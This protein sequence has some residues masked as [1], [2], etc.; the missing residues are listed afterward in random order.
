M[1]TNTLFR[2]AVVAIASNTVAAA[3]AAA[4]TTKTQTGGG[5][6]GGADQ[7]DV[8]ND[9]ISH[10][11]GWTWAAVLSAFIVYEVVLHLMR[12]VRTVACLNN[13]KQRYFAVPNAT[14]GKFKRYLLDAPLFRTRH[15]R[16]FR[17]SAALNIGTLPSRLQMG[18]LV[19]YF[20]TNVAFCVIS[21]DWSA[22]LAEVAPELRNRTGVLAVMNM[23]PLFLL[24]GRNNPFIAL[25]GISFD[26]FNLIHRWIGRI[27]VF[28]A[29]THTAAYLATKI[30][31]V[32]WAGFAE[33]L[34]K[35]DFILSGFVGACAF[36]FLLLHSPSAIRHAFYETFLHAH[37]LV[38]ATAVGAVWIH[39][40]ELP[41]LRILYGVVTIWVFER[42]LR[43]FRIIL[44]NIGSGGTKADIEALP[45]DA[46]RVTI[47]MARPWKFRPGQHVYIY[48]P[49]IG[50]WTNHPFSLAWSEEEEDLSS[51][52]SEKRLSIPMSTQDV[53]AMR[54]TTMS[55]IVRRRT[56]FTDRL[57]RR[58]AASATGRITTTAVVEGPY[59]GE[60]LS[61]YGTVM[62][63]AA[64]IGIAHQVPHVR[65][66]VG[67]FANGTT[68]TRRL[69]LVWIIQSPEHLEW[70]RPWMT[71]ILAMPRRRE[72]LKILLFVT[73]PRSTKEIQSP[74]ASVQMFPGK[75][76]VEALVEQ[77]R[78]E[79]VGAAVVSCCGTGSLADE[80]R[81]A[82]RTR[83][84]TWN[85]DFRE[86]S[87]SW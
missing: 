59:G 12:Y 52:S 21:I 61:S 64:G 6:T 79:S 87:F 22:P 80:L 10:W 33:T 84:E 35:S 78:V 14:Y 19:A 69:T 73:R 74:S 1:S 76:N 39:L 60:S 45:G 82:V 25:C 36:T 46:V 66:I 72:V 44:R 47:R 5:T 81:R 71:T 15:H 83:E 55:L 23:L 7:A 75:P 11:L 3:A 62:L 24:A 49:S 58:A 18:Y 56:G 20:G 50:L 41:Q 37:I 86:E 38:A 42:S 68:A 65:S 63:W 85:V 53:L 67:A 13:E 43:L 2:W 77:E 31:Q 51:A 54:K 9:H 30:P 17:F 26:T 48:M 27:V 28:E 29:I 32:G 16:E 57:Y 70:I 8:E 34:Q 40:K 4:N